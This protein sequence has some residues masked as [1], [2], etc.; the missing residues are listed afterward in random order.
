MRVVFHTEARLEFNAAAI[1]YKHEAG[2]VIAHA[3]RNEVERVAKLLEEYPEFG[4]PLQD[5][6]ASGLRR[7]PCPRLL[8]EL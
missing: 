2:L 1:Y 7:Y 8:Q 3:F 4:T 5:S 6:P